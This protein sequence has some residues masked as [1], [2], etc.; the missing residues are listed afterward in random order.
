MSRKFVVPYDFI[1]FDVSGKVGKILRRNPYFN[2]NVYLKNCKI[3]YVEK[4]LL[5][6]RQTVKVGATNCIVERNDGKKNKSSNLPK[7]E[8]L[9]WIDEKDKAV[10]KMEIYAE[11]ELSSEDSKPIVI[12]ETILVP[13]GFWF[14]KTITVNTDNKTIFNKISGD[15]KT[16][17]Y[18]YKKFNVEVKKAEVDKN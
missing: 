11:N 1:T 9:I 4:S 17:F 7:S 5:E 8:A 18:N 16:E 6:N 13:E 10:I 15:W 14:W 3:N 2:P 12:L